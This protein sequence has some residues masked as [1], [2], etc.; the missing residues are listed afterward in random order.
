MIAALKDTLKLQNVPNR[1]FHCNPLVPE[2]QDKPFS[3]QIT[4]RSQFKVKLRIFFHP[5]Q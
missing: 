5:G 2:R 4:I 1:K 3:L